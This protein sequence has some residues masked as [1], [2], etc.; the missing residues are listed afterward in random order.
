M[1]G[2]V[3]F[4]RRLLLAVPWLLVASAP[5]GV[6]GMLAHG[7]GWSWGRP[8]ALGALT[9]FVAVAATAFL[10]KFRAASRTRPGRPETPPPT[11]PPTP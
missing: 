4:A 3:F 7:Q 5:V 10:V 6:V 1:S 8:L 2:R 9:T 11:F